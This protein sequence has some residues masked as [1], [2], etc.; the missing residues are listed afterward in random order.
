MSRYA[1]CPVCG[2][3]LRRERDILGD[4]DGETYVCDHCA[5][6][7]DESDDEAISVYDAAQIWLSNGKDEDY[8]FGFSEEELENA[9]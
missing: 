4:W 3:K 8:T 6:I 9:L 5:G 7:E 1:M 2:R